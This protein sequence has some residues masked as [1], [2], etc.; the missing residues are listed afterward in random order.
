MISQEWRVRFVRPELPRPQSPLPFV[1]DLPKD[2]EGWLAGSGLEAGTPFLV[3]PLLE[4]DVVLNEFWRD[5]LMRGAAATTQAGYAR[6]VAA[7]LTFLWAA[8]GGI[9]WRDATEDDHLAYLVW[10]RRDPDGPR[11]AGATWDREVAAVNRFYRWALRYGHVQRNPVPQVSRRPAGPGAGWGGRRVLDEQRPATYSHDAV[12]ERVQWLPP[13]AYRRWRDVGV[14]GFTA[15]GLPRAGFR[16]RWASRNAVFCDLMVRTGLRLSEQVSLT[17]FEVPVVPEGGGYQ[18]FW[19]P[20]VVAKGRSARWV[21]VPTAVVADL[22]SYVTWDRE[23]VVSHARSHGRYAAWRRPWV[24]E[25]PQRP[26]ARRVGGSQGVPVD[27]L[28]AAQRRE[29]LVDGPEG[30]A[31]A[32]FWLS[33]RGLPLSV[34]AWKAMFT[35]AN[36]RCE[37]AGLAVRCHAH[38]LRHSFAVI[39]LEQ[40]QRGHLAALAEAQP[41]EREYYVRIFGDPLDWVRRRLGHRSVV[42]TQVYL[43]ALADLEMQTRMALVPD[44]WQTPP[45]GDDDVAQAWS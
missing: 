38:L 27:R 4:Y 9:S 17:V 20:E 29:L 28:D 19:L 23:E 34:S 33:E 26:V 6:D 32:C 37:S 24:V 10:R 3:S 31:P 42:T 39:T 44:G 41:R 13:E 40:L 7:F 2:W 30:L 45:A 25:D 16:G 1:K 15:E 14:R 35:E 43:H 12:R 11:V 18:R 8:R 5:P 21:Y 22:G 36:R